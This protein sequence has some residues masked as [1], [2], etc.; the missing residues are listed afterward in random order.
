MPQA[1]LGGVLEHMQSLLLYTRGSPASSLRSDP[2]LG[3]GLRCWGLHSR[4]A[5]LRMCLCPGACH[6]LGSAQLLPRPACS[7]LPASPCPLV[8]CWGGWAAG[9]RCA[10]GMTLQTLQAGWPA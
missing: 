2:R 6:G 7:L 1:F 5:A 10:L 8:T 3:N 4:M 9:A